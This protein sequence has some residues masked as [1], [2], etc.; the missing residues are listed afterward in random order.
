MGLIIIKKNVL[1][2]SIHSHQKKKEMER[3]LTY[4]EWVEKYKVS[5]GYV[6]PT[7]YFQGNPSSGFKPIENLTT[8]QRFLKLLGF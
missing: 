3:E 4:N 6:E 1:Y 2:L 8:F 5:S 7:K